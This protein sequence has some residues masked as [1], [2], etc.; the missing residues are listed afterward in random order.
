MTTFIEL[1]DEVQWHIRHRRDLQGFVKSKINQAV[2]DVMR[3]VKPPEFLATTAITTSDGVSAYDLGSQ[4]EDVLAVLGVAIDSTSVNVENRRLL[5]GRYEEYDEQDPTNTGRPRKWF[6]YGNNLILYNRVPDDNDGDNYDLTVRILER[7][8]ALSA[9]ADV[10]PLQLELEELVVLRAASK[11][12]TLL[13]NLERKQVSD[14]L[15][16]E[17]LNFIR[18]IEDFENMADRDATMQAGTHR[19]HPSSGRSRR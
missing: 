5:R 17:S 19:T 1:Q 2:L 15:F 13:G 16:T 14:D 11:M 10:F 18:Q 9:D 12:F 7:P 6:R 4:S 8:T 3:I